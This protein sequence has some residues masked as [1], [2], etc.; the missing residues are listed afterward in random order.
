MLRSAIMMTRPV[1]TPMP[2]ALGRNQALDHGIEKGDLVDSLRRR[3]GSLDGQATNV[4]PA[5]LQQRHEVVNSQHD[6][7]DKLLSVHANVANGD[8]HAQNLLQLEL[9]GRLDFDDLCGKVIGVRN[10]SRE[11]AS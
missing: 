11:L 6:V 2:K 8:T 7:S 3:H 10:G 5:L 9:D 4:L 1:P